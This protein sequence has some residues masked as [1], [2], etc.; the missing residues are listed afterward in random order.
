MECYL[1]MFFYVF[2]EGC[3]IG[4]GCDMDWSEGGSGI[5]GCV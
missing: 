3:C 4:L 1:N 2:V 5:V